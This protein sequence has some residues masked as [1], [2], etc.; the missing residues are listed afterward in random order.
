VG[1]FNSGRPRTRVMVEDCLPL[2]AAFLGKLGCFQGFARRS[3]TW[4][5]NDKVS[6]RGTIV[7]TLFGNEPP[8]AVL[9]LDGL[10]PQTIL[11]VFT[12]PKLGGKRWW[13]VCPTTGRRCRTLY[14]TPGGD[15]FASRQAANWS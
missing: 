13:F 6:A 8:R 11:L 9:R 1:G 7:V 3:L 2:D 10:A 12:T 4:V 15:R 5:Y 14:L